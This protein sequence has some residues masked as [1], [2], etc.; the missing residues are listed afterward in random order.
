MC[1]QNILIADQPLPEVVDDP[2]FPD[3]AVRRIDP[4][5]ELVD[6]VRRVVP[7]APYLYLVG[8]SELCGCYFCCDSAEHEARLAGEDGAP[9]PTGDKLREMDWL[10]RQGHNSVN[11][12]GR[13]LDRHAQRASLS[14][15]VCWEREEGLPLE[16]QQVVAPSFFG[17]LQ[18]ARLPE[19]S[20]FR[21]SPR[22]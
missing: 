19:N 20:L 10:W 11:S 7:V 1:V 18:F 22:S 3:L 5:A 21:I 15:Y 6:G 4:Y 17:G 13:Y 16:R 9:P 2:E 14:L 12:F 8:P